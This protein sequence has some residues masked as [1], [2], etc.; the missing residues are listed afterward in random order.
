MSLF[1]ICRGS[2]CTVWLVFA[3]LLDVLLLPGLSTLRAAQLPVPHNQ[4]QTIQQ[5]TRLSKQTPK[6]LDYPPAREAPPSGPK[7]AQLKANFEKMKSNA[8][9]LAELANS[10]K[11]DLEKANPNV[12]P[13]QLGEKAKH[14]DKLAKQIK[15]AS[16]NF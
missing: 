3:L 8:A 4:E 15:K 16:G 11:A 9:T 6:T 12:L 1:S 14:I 7:Q 13:A 2:Y 10:L 5:T